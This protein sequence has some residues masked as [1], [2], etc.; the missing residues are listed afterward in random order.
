MTEQSSQDSAALRAR[1]GAGVTLGAIVMLALNLRAGVSSL[2]PV[3]GQVRAALGVSTSTAGLL[4]ALPGLCFALMGWCAVPL[5]RKLGLT[6]T[7]LCGVLAIAAGLALRP[8]LGSFA[9]FFLCTVVV[10]AGIAVAN[11]LLPAWIK[12]TRS[13]LSP[14][15]AMSA[16]TAVLGLSGAVGPLSSLLLR[17]W[18]L[19]LVVW[20][21]P[22]VIALAWWLPLA[23]R[24]GRDVPRGTQVSGGKPM[25]T[26]PTAWYLLGFFGLQ[27]AGAYVQMGWLPQMLADR[28]VGADVA[29]WALILIGSMNIL[30]GVLMP[31]L[32]ARMRN[33]VPVPIALSLI[34]A[35]GWC[36]VLWQP[37]SAPLLWGLLL[38]IGGMCF[39]LALA[40]LGQRTRS[41]LVTARL[42]GFVQPGGYLMAGILPFLVGVM[43]VAWGG[44]TQVLVLLIVLSLVMAWCGARACRPVVVDEELAQRTKPRT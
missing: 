36:G 15:V 12:N 32:C 31:W 42:S 5:A 11:V 29:A 25:R 4:T 18:Q 41:P 19:V 13:A 23:P 38:G 28:G 20:A 2:A 33:L 21:L 24:L 40:L 22:A 10:V 6:P 14:V 35:I 44:W 17:D 26:S 27:S 37:T 8:W 43:S 16:Y 39:P 34:T 1:L 30:G 3:L 7:L 9:L